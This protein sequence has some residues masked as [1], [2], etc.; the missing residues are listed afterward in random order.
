MLLS[1]IELLLIELPDML[2]PDI[3]LSDMLL[4]EDIELPDMEFEL[5]LLLDMEFEDMPLSD[6]ELSLP[7]LPQADRPTVSRAAAVT[8]I[9]FFIFGAFLEN[10]SIKCT[11]YPACASIR[12]TIVDAETDRSLNSVW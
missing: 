2:L 9:S 5:M 8:R 11:R 10:C 7:L 6:A 4:P 1:D 3:E 12:D